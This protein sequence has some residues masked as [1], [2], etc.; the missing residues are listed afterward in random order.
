MKICYAF[1]WYRWKAKNILQ[2]FWLKHFFKI[3]VFMSK[4]RLK[5]VP[6]W[7]FLLSHKTVDESCYVIDG[8]SQQFVHCWKIRAIFVKKY[9]MFCWI[10]KKSFTRA[11]QSISQVPYLGIFYSRRIIFINAG[12]QRWTSYNRKFD[13]KTTIF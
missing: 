13:M 1:Y 7:F 12:H 5:D 6:R 4:F 8:R 10:E 3:V 2:R 11:N 9:S